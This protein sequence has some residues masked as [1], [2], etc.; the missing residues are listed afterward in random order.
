MAKIVLSKILKYVFNRWSV[1]PWL[2]IATYV[3]TEIFARNPFW[4]EK[5]Y[6]RGIYPF[7]TKILSKTSSFFPFSLD[8]IFYLLLIFAA[9]VIIILS[10]FK[11]IS[12]KN[13][14]KIVLNIFA[15]VYILFYSLWGYNYFRNNINQRIDLAE[16]EPDA[17]EFI[18]VL[19]DLIVKTNNSFCTFNNFNMIE[20]ER[21]IEKSYNKL[22]PVLQINY[23]AGKRRA[24]NITFSRFFAKAGISG[25]YGPFFS[26]VHINKN[27]LPVEY[28]FVLAHEKAHQFGISSEAEANFYAWLVCSQSES[29]QLQYSANLY[30]LK[31]FIYQGYQME[32][33]PEI[34]KELNGNVKNDF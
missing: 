14:G 3:L 32:Q 6:S 7:V 25:Y 24:K 1:L 4:A 22:A 16:R 17:E 29:K 11:K 20:I 26:E 33:Y 2:A 34:I 18:S 21:L 27:N 30:I 9:V 31:F 12:L 23:P 19:K 5:I 10:I 8:D 13:S 28:P 15:S